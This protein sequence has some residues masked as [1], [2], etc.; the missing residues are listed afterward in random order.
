MGAAITFIII[1]SLGAQI[2]T[3]IRNG[4]RK[5][6]SDIAFLESPNRLLSRLDNEANVEVAKTLQ[7]VADNLSGFNA[8]AIASAVQGALAS[9]DSPL[10]LELKQLINN[11]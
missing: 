3:K 6:L 2:R 10:V 9:P 11:T 1:L 8:D 5:K 4:L 7:S